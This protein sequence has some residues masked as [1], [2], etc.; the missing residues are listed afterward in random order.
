MKI[1]YVKIRKEAKG[2]A[3]MMHFPKETLMPKATLNLKETSMLRPRL[4]EMQTLMQRPR[5]M[6]KHS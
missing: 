4:K 3:K 1:P 2:W 5:P 6:Q